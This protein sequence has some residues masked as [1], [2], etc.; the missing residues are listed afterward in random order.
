MCPSTLLVSTL[1]KMGRII[2]AQIYFRKVLRNPKSKINE[3]ESVGN[4][5]NAII[6]VRKLRLVFKHYLVTW[7]PSSI[8]V[9]S[10]IIDV[11]AFIS[12]LLSGNCDVAI[13]MW[14]LKTKWLNLIILYHI[15]DV[16]LG[17]RNT[18]L[19][20]NHIVFCC[21]H[22]L[23]YIEIHFPT[24]SFGLFFIF[25]YGYPASFSTA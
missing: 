23:G 8:Q 24:K 9:R 14:E 17:K 6:C 3:W 15:K 22:G 19:V 12:W 18:F 1:L 21:H 2:C 10:L 13:I 20:P 25:I 4:I 16:R 7:L 5:K 11:Y